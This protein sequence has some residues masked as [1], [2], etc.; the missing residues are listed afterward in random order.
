MTDQAGAR[1]RWGAA[2]LLTA[3]SL[4]PLTAWI[5][6]G[7]DAGLLR[8]AADEWWSGSLI[9]A[10]VAVLLTY[11][12]RG[13]PALWR[14]EGWS[15]LVARADLL[16]P[17]RTALVAAFG[18]LLYMALAWLIHSARPL[19]IDELVQ[20]WQARVYA[21][22]HLWVPSTGHPELFGITNTVDHA[23][24]VFGQFPAGGPAMLALGSLV[25]A[26]WIVGPLFA[27]LGL[28]WWGATLRRTGEPPVSATNA[29]LL[30]LLAPF[31]LFMSASHMNH[32]TA[33]TWTLGGIAGLAAVVTSERPRPGMALGLGLAF[34][35]AA[36]IRPVD[37]AA[38]GA[39]AGLWLFVR[40]LR[41]RR[42]ALECVLA[43][44]GMALPMV[45]TFYV[46]AQTTGHPLLFGYTM[47]WGPEH[48][49]GFHEG[50]WGPPHT[51]LRGL[52]QI[53]GYLIHLQVRLLETPFPSLLPALAVLAFGGP[54][55]PFD[56]YL[57][58][59]SALILG[60]YWAYWHNG[61]YLGP[62]FLY[63]VVP[64]AL[65]LTARWGSVV[66]E[67]W[68]SGSVPHRLWTYAALVG[69]VLAVGLNIPL[70]GKQYAHA[71]LTPRRR[72]QVD[73]AA[74][75]A[76]NALVL[77]RQSWGAQVVTRMWGRGLTP[78]TEEFVYWRSD[79][80]AIEETLGRLERAGMRDKGAREALVALTA[81][82]LRVVDSVLSAD[83]TER[84]L[85]DALYTPTC[86]QRVLD[87]R[88]GFTVYPP[89]VLDNVS[90]NVY[91]QDQHVLDT[92]ALAMYPDR[93]VFLLVPDD[94]TRG[95]PPRFHRA[96]RDSLLRAWGLP[97]D[98]APAAAR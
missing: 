3:L 26:E 19:L 67:K 40:A 46:N 7:Q 58:L 43:G 79:M 97:P 85:P 22:G 80:C 42:R 89:T 72:I 82:S 93:A 60:A 13:V 38:F 70:R 33:L 76:T 77:V 91:V 28:W 53:N 81:D 87:D 94:T 21:S 8:A 30:L 62:R 24:R 29:L 41:D 92:A 39:P 6:G 69:G 52:E 18:A 55:K 95:A 2:G 71:L 88:R 68:G 61:F 4:L 44:A 75:G 56:R 64:F 17:R 47:L 11:L 23:G 65:L 32:V 51:P 5:P 14:A 48:G 36:S 37:A 12:A 45:A 78:S 10:G 90:G 1:L 25:G 49:L 66:R 74:A 20:V 84:L 35:L 63:S 50:P 98:W 83:E 96:P 73:A 31:P 34:G 86:Y 59:G 54:L 57:A 9:V 15:G 16:A 27:A